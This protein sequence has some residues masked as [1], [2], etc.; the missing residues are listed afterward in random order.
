[1]IQ[2]TDNKPQQQR[3][4]CLDKV[5]GLTAQE[6]GSCKH[7]FMMINDLGKTFGQADVDERGQEERREFRGVVAERRCGKTRR[8][9]SR[10]FRS[11]S[12]ARSSTR[13]ISEA[14]RKFLA[15]LLSQLTDQQLR[16]LFEVARFTKRDPKY[17]GRRLGARVQAEA[18]RDRERELLESRSLTGDQKTKRVSFLKKS[19]DLLTLLSPFFQA[20]ITCDT[21]SST[22]TSFFTCVN[23]N[24]PSPR[25]VRASRSITPRSAPDERREIRLVDDEQ[26]GLRDARPAFA[27]NLVAARHV[28]HVNRVIGEV[29]AELRGKVI[30]AALDEQ[31]LRME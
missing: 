1:M 9:A 13:K 2:H 30:A 7:P 5:R 23:R 18:R 29:A 24:G 10:S 31:Q 21:T 3:L 26:I 4:V 22:P 17:S 28:D 20:A 11:R 27:R 16:D 8:A 12:P 15:G 14:G 6:D 25:I 19:S